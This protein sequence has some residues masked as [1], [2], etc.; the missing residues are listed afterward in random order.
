MLKL[1]GGE[2]NIQ[3]YTHCMTRLR[4]NL[5]ENGAADRIKLKELPG[6]MDVNI[7]GG[8]FQV[9][10]GNDVSKVYGELSKIAKKTM[11]ALPRRTL[12]NKVTIKGR[13]SALRLRLASFFAD[14]LPG[15]FNPIVPAI[16]GAGMIKALLAVIV[17]FNATAANTDLYKI[18]NIIS[19]AVFYFLPMLLAF[20]SAKKF[21]VNPYLAVVIG[22][23]LLHP[24]FAKFMAD[25]IT[26]MSF[27][28]LPV[29]LVSYSSSVIP[30]IATVWI[31]SYVERF[32]RKIVPNVLKTI[33]EP[34]LILLI[35]APIALIVIGPLGIYAGNAIADGYMYF[36]EHF[37]VIAGTLL[38]AT[39]SLMVITGLHYGLIPLVFQAIAQNGFDYIMPIMTVANIAQAGAVFAVFL[40]TKK[41]NNMKSLSGASTISALMGISE[42]AIYGVNLKLKKKPFIAGLIGSAAGAFILSIFQVAAYALGKVGLPSLPLY[43]GHKFSLMILAVCVSFVVAAVVAYVLGFKDVTEAPAEENSTD[44]PKPSESVPVSAKKS[45]KTKKSMLPLQ[46]RLKA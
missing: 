23:V 24:N 22:G 11:L 20:S 37:G 41:N 1:V 17:M 19:D 13:S 44:L 6:V 43:I 29:K 15:I 39:F 21:N 14:I 10:I 16:A 4:F 34:M 12:N 35:V 25:G 9:I 27:L 28:G 5:R 7:N 2:D 18:L 45:C 31:M 42:P 32:V 38:G 36:Y 30:I 40:K 33:L 3:D 26:S 46:A 8:Q